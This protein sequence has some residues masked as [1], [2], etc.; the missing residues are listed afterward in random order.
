M[1]AA[2]RLR[3]RRGDFIT[4]SGRLDAD[5]A[6]PMELEGYLDS[7]FYKYFAPVELGGGGFGAG[8]GFPLFEGVSYV[9]KRC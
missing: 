1:R 9:R 8:E 3:A 6:A 4:F 2:L 7:G 5:Y